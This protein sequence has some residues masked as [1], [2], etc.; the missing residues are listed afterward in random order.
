MH[1]YMMQP[2]FTPDG[3]SLDLSIG[4]EALASILEAAYMAVEDKS[5]VYDKT[6]RK[7][8]Q[9][10]FIFQSVHDLQKAADVMEE[11]EIQFKT[12]IVERTS[13]SEADYMTDKYFYKL[14]VPGEPDV[15][16]EDNEYHP[17]IYTEE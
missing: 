5:K 16:G 17:R 14:L 3:H 9:D 1:Y 7:N 8:H 12:N 2:F 13:R 10:I 15:E 4:D 11:Y 6:I